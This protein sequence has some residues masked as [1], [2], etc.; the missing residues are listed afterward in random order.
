M[1]MSGIE[2][3]EAAALKFETFKREK[4]HCAIIFEI[5]D[6]ED[7]KKVIDVH[8]LKPREHESN[9]AE[10]FMSIWQRLSR[11]NAYYIVWDFCTKKGEICNN[12]LLF[13]SW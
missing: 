11:N 7:K 12:R 1:A 5:K 8:D 9:D 6:C 4:K 10:E 13:T 3:L 2:V